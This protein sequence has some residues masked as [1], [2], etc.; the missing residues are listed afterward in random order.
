[1]LFRSLKKAKTFFE[2]RKKIAQKYNAAFAG[3]DSF[4]LPPDGEGN[5]WYF[6]ILRLNFE[7]LKIGR[8][9]FGQALQEKGLGIFDALYTSF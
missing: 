5:A 9:E 3:N 4:I 2:Q 7:A 8:D 6:Y 1:M